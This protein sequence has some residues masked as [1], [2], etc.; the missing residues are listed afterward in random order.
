LSI[1]AFPKAFKAFSSL[2]RNGCAREE[3]AHAEKRA[4][5]AT[6]TSQSQT[7]DIR[8]KLVEFA[9]WMKKQGYAES[10]IMR[11][12]KALEVLCKRG[13]NLYDPESVK[14]VISKQNW[15]ENGKDVVVRARRWAT[16]MVILRLLSL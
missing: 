7:T 12:V 6:E 8:G 16:L 3:K 4:A 15:S 10:T 9:W 13:A 1:L 5:G 2:I 11:R 14:E